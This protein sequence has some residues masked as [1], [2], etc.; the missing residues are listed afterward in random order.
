MLNISLDHNFSQDL[1]IELKTCLWNKV[2][3]MDILTW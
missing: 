2:A 1:D 3:E